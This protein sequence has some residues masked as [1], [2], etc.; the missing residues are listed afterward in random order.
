MT[1]LML[2]RSYRTR[3]SRSTYGRQMRA[4]LAAIYSLVATVP[5]LKRGYFSMLPLQYPDL[6][7]YVARMIKCSKLRRDGSSLADNS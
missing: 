4:A 6:G 7:R 2:Q 1:T 5:T 3:L